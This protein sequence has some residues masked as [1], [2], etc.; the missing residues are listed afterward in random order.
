MNAYRVIAL[1]LIAAGLTLVPWYALQDSFWA[2]KWIKTFGGKDFAPALLQAT[3][4]GR[5][6]LWPFAFLLVAAAALLA[7]PW[8]EPKPWARAV[9]FVGIFG[10]G[11]LLAQG[12]A[13]SGQGYAFESLK[14]AF[15]AL[16]V[17]QYGMGAGALLVAFGFILIAA[18]GV[19]SMG[20]FRGDRFVASSLIAVV[21]LVVLFVFFPVL[22]VLWAG[23]LD[24]TGA[25]SIG[26]FWER[27]ATSKIWALTPA[28]LWGGSGCGVAW[29]T[30]WLALLCAAGTTFLGLMLAL[31][32][33]RTSVRGKRVLR[34]LTVLPIITP[35]FVVGLGLIMLF[36]RAGIVNDFLEWAFAIEPTRWIYG[37]PGVLLAQL[38]AFTP[39]AFLVLIGVV[40]G[41]SP[42]LEEASQSLHAS[43]WQTFKTVTLPLMAPGL[44]NAFLVGFIESIADFGNPV[45]LGGNFSVLSTEIYFAIVGA[46]LDQGK[47]AVLSM[48]LLAMALFA[49]W[50]QQ[51][52]TRK[53]NFVTVTGKGDTGLPVPL[54]TRVHRTAIGIAI[55]WL[56]LTVI[57]YGMALVGGFTKVWGRDHTFTLEHF[58]KAFSVDYGQFGLQWTGAAWN[59]LFNTLTFSLVAAP[60]TAIVG[61]LSAYLIARTT[62][63]GQ[64]G[65]EFLTL[66]SFAIPGTVIGVAYIFAFNV[67][68]IEITGTGLI[69]VLCFVFRNLPVGVRGG[70]AALS[71][72]D[73]SLDEA[74]TTLGANGAKTFRHVLFPLLKP[75]IVGALVYG[76]V[77]SMTTVSAIIFLV[78][79]ET[80]VATTYIIGRVVNGD[81]GVSIAYSAVLIVLMIIV[82]LLIQWAVGTRKL[83]RRA[84]VSGAPS[85]AAG[86]G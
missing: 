52:A 69:I 43:R 83:G 39:V 28:C 38:F 74:S 68:P 32:A 35:P 72:I 5:G 73:K 86:G 58:V 77:R 40:E 47:A 82:I 9:A 26:A 85:L 20:Y 45:V 10:V 63:K 84:G 34:L 24:S 78:S 46:Q 42:T 29:N 23:I 59:S 7:K 6:W 75:A 61:I 64:R 25:L 76:F 56:A 41:V 22:R 44:A 67:P 17:G 79:G 71:Q 19:A 54:D 57:I 18:D 8:R 80:E 1:L 60:L 66:L 36:G 4:H 11:Y 16:K 53:K 49:F 31:I 3:T 65:F 27:L 51:R 2:F 30:L 62:F 21:S 33:T 50:L 48:L 37:L 55:P 12:F 70:I 13:I 81:Y 14:S 15:P